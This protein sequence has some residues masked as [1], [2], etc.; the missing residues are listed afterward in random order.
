MT[1]RAA[2]ISSI[3]R[4]RYEH[5]FVEADPYQGFP[6]AQSEFPIADV[7]PI[8]CMRSNNMIAEV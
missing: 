8:F 5:T 1:W 2:A 6:I 7:L 3:Y 4:A